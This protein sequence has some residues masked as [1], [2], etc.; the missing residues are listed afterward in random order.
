[1]HAVPLFRRCAAA[2]IAGALW[3]VAAYAQAVAPVTRL[4]MDD[5][6]RLAVA[7]NQALQAQ[8]LTIDASKA[9]EIT[10]GLKPNPSLSFS[11]SGFPAFSFSLYTPDYLKNTLTYDVGASYL[12][13]R[14]GKRKNR[15]LVAENTTD[16]AAKTVND[17]ER[18]LRFQTAQAFISVLLAKSA[19]DLAQQDLQSFSQVVELNRQRVQ[20]GDLAE[21]DFY[22]ISLQKLQFEQDVS[23]AQVG[24]VQARAALRQ[25]VGF[26]TVADNFD[27][28]GE[29]AHAPQ[30]LN[31]DELKREALDAR[32][33]LQAARSNVTL[34]KNTLTLQQSNAKR[35]V[36]GGIDYLRNDVGPFSSLN[37][38]ASID[39]P[40]H[41]RNQGNIAKSEVQ[42]RQASESEQAAEYLVLTDV[43]NAYAGW[44]TADQILKV[45]ESGYLNQ[46]K[47]SLDVSQ[48][49]F[50]RG[51]GT[52]LD[53]L[54]A[55]RTYRDTQLGYRQALAA[56][57]TSVAQLNLAVGRQVLP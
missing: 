35:D 37:V 15:I 4:T 42:V 22:K 57:M 38:G 31:L 53:L 23:S 8:R 14:G 26:D 9:D 24:L 44:Q 30:T 2:V 32:P 36:S 56:Y 1:M 6:V 16:V 5:A 7:R 12:F 34:A 3:P 49:V 52:L 33:D 41:D 21:A 20:A 11:L 28:V 13:E 43:T 48:Y 39:L 18:Q 40:I 17:A 51:A 29:L 25:F 27:V 45:Y 54:D 55:E 47:Q 46:A 50:Q 19:L 10:A